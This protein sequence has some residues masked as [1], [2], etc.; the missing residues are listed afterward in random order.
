MFGSGYV[1]LLAR[2]ITSDLEQIRHDAFWESRISKEVLRVKLTS[3]GIDFGFIS[4]HP[5]GVVDTSEIEGLDEDLII[6]PFG[7]KGSTI[8]LR[9]FTISALNLH[10]GIQAAETYGIGK[11]PDNDGVSDE[12]SIGDI[13]ALTL[14]QATLPAPQRVYPEAKEANKAAVIGENLFGSIGCVACHIPQLPLE[15]SVFIEPN[16]YNPPRIYRQENGALPFS[17][18]LAKVDAESNFETDSEGRMMVPIFT[19][20][21]RHDMGDDLDNEKVGQCER[22]NSGKCFDIPSSHWITKKLWGFASEPPFLHHGRATLISEAIQAHGGEAEKS[23]SKFLELDPD[24]K[25]AVVEFLKSLKI[26]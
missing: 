1:E 15:S 26:S 4:V 22:S 14:F 24:D 23:R 3:K 2:E 13:T 16:P 20:F 11:D 25:K 8:S 7:Q 18:D 9:Q 6:K 10:H 21:K 19:D 17:I 12:L 5:N